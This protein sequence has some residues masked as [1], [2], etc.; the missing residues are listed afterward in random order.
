MFHIPPVLVYLGS[1][2][3]YQYLRSRNTTVEPPVHTS[4]TWSGAF[5][6]GVSRIVT[7]QWVDGHLRRDCG[8]LALR[9]TADADEYARGD[10]RIT[11]LPTARDV[12]WAEVPLCL[13]VRY[14]TEGEKNRV[15]FRFAS[16]DSLTFDPKSAAFF[17]RK[18]EEE[19]DLILATFNARSSATPP[20]QTD[21][22]VV[23]D[24]ELLGVRRDATWV[25]VQAA[26]REA[27]L[28][29]HPDRLS[30]SGLPEH[31]LELAIREF[32]ART[33]AYQRL[34]ALLN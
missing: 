31:L 34:K 3:L 5:T 33:A 9:S 30:A 27:C 4:L 13:T 22:G 12:R 24:F 26:Y 8:C 17:H 28:R 32:Q 6:T 11:R 16:P 21:P 14:G 10:D 19:F 7:R 20:P 1:S 2:I 15:E 18:A 29:Y 23:R 25:Q